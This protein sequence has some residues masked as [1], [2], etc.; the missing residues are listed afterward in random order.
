MMLVFPLIAVLHLALTP[1]KRFR[2]AERERF[3]WLFCGSAMLALFV[4]W[5]RTR[6]RLAW[7]FLALGLVHGGL[8]RMGRVVQGAHWSSDVLWSAGCVHIVSWWAFYALHG[9][10]EGADRA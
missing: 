5:C 2:L 7:W 8:M 6:P 10:A 4:Y 9:R 3:L 1:S